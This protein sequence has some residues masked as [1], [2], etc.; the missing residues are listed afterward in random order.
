MSF[1]TRFATNNPITVFQGSHKLGSGALQVQT[2]RMYGT[3]TITVNQSGPENQ[4]GLVQPRIFDHTGTRYKEDMDGWTST[5]G[6]AGSAYKYLTS[7][8]SGQTIA[9]DPGF[10]IDGIEIHKWQTGANTITKVT[11]Q[12]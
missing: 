10:Y 1:I 11:V 4:A 3:V 6:G 5:T 9:L 2:P 12:N 8:S 7:V